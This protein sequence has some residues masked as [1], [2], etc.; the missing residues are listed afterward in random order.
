MSPVRT[1]Q[2][3][4]AGHLS[5]RADLTHHVPRSL[6]QAAKRTIVVPLASTIWATVPAR[7]GPRVVPET[8]NVPG[9]LAIAAATH[10]EFCIVDDKGSYGSRNALN[11]YQ[12]MLT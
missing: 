4:K 9:A 6:C 8:T 12:K 7:P 2:A 10:P 1:C 3:S 5:Y 11:W